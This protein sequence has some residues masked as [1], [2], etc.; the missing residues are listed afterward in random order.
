MA[1]R[2][3]FRRLPSSFRR[4]SWRCSHNDTVIIMWSLKSGLF[5]VY[6]GNSTLI[7]LFSVSPLL[8]F[9]GGHPRKFQTFIWICRL[10][11][12]CHVAIYWTLN[13]ELIFSYYYDYYSIKSNKWQL[14]IHLYEKWNKSQIHNRLTFESSLN[15]LLPPAHWRRRRRTCCSC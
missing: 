2:Q 12:L 14:S 3:A 11:I 9:C 15:P 10:P 7:S 5:K 13:E 6:E 1:L 4:Q 8:I